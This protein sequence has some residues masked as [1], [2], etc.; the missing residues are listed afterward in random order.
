MPKL[1]HK[2]CYFKFYYSS[3]QVICLLLKNALKR[4]YESRFYINYA[5]LNFFIQYSTKNDTILHYS[6]FLC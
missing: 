6:T 3:K 4:K 5:K 1:T 2:P